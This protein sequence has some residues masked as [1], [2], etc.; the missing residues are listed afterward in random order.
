MEGEPEPGHHKPADAFSGPLA[1]GSGRGGASEREGDADRVEQA[2]G[3]PPS[4]TVRL[5]SALF[6]NNGERVNVGFPD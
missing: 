1:L 5:Q 2:G 6:W 4:L 3:G